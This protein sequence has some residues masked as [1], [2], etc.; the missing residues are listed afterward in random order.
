MFPR[1]RSQWSTT[2]VSHHALCRMLM[3][4][5]PDYL[6]AT[7]VNLGLLDFLL[8]KAAALSGSPLPLHICLFCSADTS[9]RKLQANKL[10][11]LPAEA[12]D[13]FQS[14]RIL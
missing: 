3:F 8:R 14:L 13:G 5:H 9:T 12:F 1:N 11:S 2:V 4:L 10:S 7:H 6:C